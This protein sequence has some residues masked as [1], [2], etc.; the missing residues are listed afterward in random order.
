MLQSLLS[1][2]LR[3]L[4]EQ[5]AFSQ[6]KWLSDVTQEMVWDQ[7][8]HCQLFHCIP[9]PK[10]EESNRHRVQSQG[11]TALLSRQVAETWDSQS[12]KWDSQRQRTWC[13]SWYRKT[14]RCDTEATCNTQCLR[15]WYQKQ[16][17]VSIPLKEKFDQILDRWHS[18]DIIK[19]VGDEPTDR[20]SK[21]VITPKDSENIRA[22][23][24][25]TDINK[26]VKRTRR[27]IPTLQESRLNGAK[28]FS[29]LYMND[30]YM[31]LELA[32]ESRKLT[33]FYTHHRLTVTRGYTLEWT[34]RWK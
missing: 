25:T 20:C 8:C 10:P 34:V 11:N 16:R 3:V 1:S 4:K 12:W 18:L 33:T 6:Q 9:K 21:V 31:K 5:A 24:D 14:K 27:T 15:C 13:L 30:G 19:D 23:L 26:Y 2:N 22:S 17:R 28:Y 29:H 7:Y 32:E